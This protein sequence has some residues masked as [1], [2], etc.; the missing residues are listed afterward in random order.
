MVT[1]ETLILTNCIIYFY[2]ICKCDPSQCEFISFNFHKDSHTVME[3][4]V[5]L[6]PLFFNLIMIYVLNKYTLKSA[7]F[8]SILVVGEKLEVH[9]DFIWLS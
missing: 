8:K 6:W 2:R 4:K 7:L 3:G 1:G 5:V 9:V